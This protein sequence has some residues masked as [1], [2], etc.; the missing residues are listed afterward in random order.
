MKNVNEYTRLLDTYICSCSCLLYLFFFIFWAFLHG[1]V[2][3][4]L[5]IPFGV[6]FSFIVGNWHRKVEVLLLGDNC[7]WV[8]EWCN[9]LCYRGQA[10]QWFNRHTQCKHVDSSHTMYFDII[11][12]KYNET[13]HQLCSWFNADISCYRVPASAVTW[14]AYPLQTPLCPSRIKWIWIMK[15][16][17]SWK[18]R[19][20]HKCCSTET[21]YT[22]L[23]SWAVLSDLRSKD[24]SYLGYISLLLPRLPKLPSKY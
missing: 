11:T 19:K 14:Q 5:I 9:H 4:H 13:F 6:W 15:K 16:R 22:W 18:V 21:L 20:P 23:N 7:E 17:I 10:L 3:S 2:S 24:V 1:C 12:L 8:V